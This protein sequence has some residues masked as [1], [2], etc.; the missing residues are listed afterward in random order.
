MSTQEHK[1]VDEGA[2]VRFLESDLVKHFP[3]SDAVNAALRAIVESARS[4]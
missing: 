3:A 1:Q 2:N 4:A